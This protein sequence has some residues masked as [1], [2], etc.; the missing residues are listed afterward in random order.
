MPFSFPSEGLPPALQAV[1]SAALL[2]VLLLISGEREPNSL[3]AQPA[4]DP[5][6]WT[7]S[8][9]DNDRLAPEP[10]APRSRFLHW[11]YR[12]AGA[13]LRTLGT[14]A[15]YYVLLGGGLTY[16][17]RADATIQNEIQAAYENSPALAD[18]LNLANLM[19]E[20]E[21]ALPVAGVFALSLTTDNTRFQDAA[22][23]SLQ[24]LL[25]ATVLTNALKGTVGRSRPS[26]GNGPY[27]TEAFSGH[28]SFPSG[29][30][31]TA[32]AVLTPWVLYYP[33]GATYGLFAVGAGTATARVALN[34]HWP[35]DVVA[36]AAIGILTARYLT[37]RHRPPPTASPN[38]PRLRIT[39]LVG[40]DALG[41]GLRVHFP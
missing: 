9:P 1:R 33:N 40:T 32:F 24:S 13:L 12:D 38:A 29:H 17:A 20:R 31:T 37:N 25:Y 11:T 14:D 41:V 2:L 34:R 28:T 4:P 19:G 26:V 15:P 16:G 22:F 30:T 18:A 39:P 10:T 27:N 35:T 23:T 6:L 36:G 21:V 3:R 7:A 5:V 8:L